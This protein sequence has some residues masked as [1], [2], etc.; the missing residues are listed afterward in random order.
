MYTLGK[1]IQLKPSFPLQCV[2]CGNSHNGDLDKSISDGWHISVFDSSTQGLI[3]YA[4]C[5]L[6]TK[7]WDAKAIEF[8]KR[9]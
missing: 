9:D 2:A 6:H 4:G 3:Q 7:E 8:L 5:P 1:V